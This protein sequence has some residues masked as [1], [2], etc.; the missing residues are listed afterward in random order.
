V[1]VENQLASVTSKYT[2]LVSEAEEAKKQ[3]RKRI[4]TLEADNASMTYQLDEEKR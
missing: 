3:L 1:Q 2:R 4:E